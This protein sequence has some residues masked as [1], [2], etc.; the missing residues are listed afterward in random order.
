MGLTLFAKEKIVSAKL[1]A[2]PIKMLELQF[3][4][5]DAYALVPAGYF[6]VPDTLF[7]AFIGGT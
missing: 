7:I 2:Y 3:S 6:I 5:T 4:H 1:Q